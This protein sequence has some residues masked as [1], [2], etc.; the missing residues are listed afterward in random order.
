MVFPGPDPHRQ[1]DPQRGLLTT[2]TGEPFQP[3]RLYYSLP[4]QSAVTRIFRDLHCMD[5]DRKGAR[6]VW[7]YQDEAVRLTFGRSYNQVPTA[8]HPIAIGA[9]RFP[10]TGG[11]VLS[12]RSFARAIEAAKFFAPLLGPSVVLR[13]AR[14]LNR[15]LSAAEAQRDLAA[16]DRYL[17]RNV[18]VIDPRIGEARLIA[19]LEQGG[20]QPMNPSP[21]PD[22]PEVEDFPLAPEEETADFQHLTITLQIRLLRAEEH[23]QG[24][25]HVRLRDIL[26]RC[27]ES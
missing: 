9:F 13:R 6:W 15:W 27:I 10:K 22:V 1:E 19:F 23:W 7:L 24:N 4:S 3:A 14:V 12:V 17:D 2:V 21:E 26:L 8:A 16:L 20:Q 18:T 11:M 5:E 25:T